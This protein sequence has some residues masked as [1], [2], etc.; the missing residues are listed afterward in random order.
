VVEAALGVGSCSWKGEAKEFPRH[1]VRP[2]EKFGV[3]GYDFRGPNTEPQEMA[4]DV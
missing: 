3:F 2:P 1:P 4:L